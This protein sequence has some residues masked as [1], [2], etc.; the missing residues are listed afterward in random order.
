[1]ARLAVCRPREGL[2]NVTEAVKY[3]LKHLAQAHGDTPQR[4]EELTTQ[5]RA[6]LSTHYPDLLAVYGVG[7]IV[8]AQ[9]VVTIGGNPHRIRSEAAFASLCGASPIL[10]SSGK[11]TR[12]IMRCPKR[13]V[14]R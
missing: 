9:L 7:P 2:S 10:A 5:I 14:A 1:I 6:I 13:A 3:T 11:T 12:E 4:V 8:A